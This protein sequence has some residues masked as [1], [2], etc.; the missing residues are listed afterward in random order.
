MDTARPAS[1]P[2]LFIVIIA[3]LGVIV[4][5]TAAAGFW[6]WRNRRQRRRLQL[7]GRADHS[8]TGI[9]TGPY[10]PEPLDSSAGHQLE[11]YT[12]IVQ[13]LIRGKNQHAIS[14][15]ALNDAPVYT[16]HRYA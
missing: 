13:P 5:A 2:L 15:G 7:A 11:H 12:P 6:I 14:E 1:H 8:S 16:G 10:A 4:I 9:T 3:L